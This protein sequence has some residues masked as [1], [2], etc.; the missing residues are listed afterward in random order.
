MFFETGRD[1]TVYFSR[2]DNAC[3]AH[4]HRSAELMYV[5]C[6]HKTALLNGREYTL[7]AGQIL[8]C[9]PYAVH[10]FPPCPGSEQIVAAVPAD[11]CARFEKFCETHEAETPV[12]DDGDGSLLPL[13]SA[14]EK[15]GN[16]VLC[17]GLTNCILGRYL[18]RTAFRPARRPPD[19]SQV[20]RIAVYIDEHY[21]SPLSL[22][23]LAGA[24]GYSPNYFSALFKKY[25]RTG[26][27]QYVNSVRVQKSLPLLKT[28]K[29]SAVYFL[30]GFRSPQQYFLNFR[31][32]FG[33]TP[34]EYLHA[35][36]SR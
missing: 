6:G 26:V 3:G 5:L 34:Y 17:E 32:F 35:Q 8:V 20:E 14:L 30:C 18:E 19:R 7:S 36:K 11:Y 29:I 10:M 9:P 31:K 24:F 33:C 16:D 25:F 22:S 27:A 15:A 23:S 4:F 12:F 28:R 2:R 21:A 13:F 1:R